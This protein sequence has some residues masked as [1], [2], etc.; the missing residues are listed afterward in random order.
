M[1]LNYFSFTSCEFYCLKSES[2]ATEVEKSHHYCTIHNKYGFISPTEMGHKCLCLFSLPATTAAEVK[3]RPQFRF[4][5]V[6][7][8]GHYDT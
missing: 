7:V 2:R 8:Q 6:S 4:I 3:A 5:G 1:L